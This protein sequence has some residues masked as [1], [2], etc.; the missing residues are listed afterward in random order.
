MR[1]RIFK[2]VVAVEFLNRALRPP[3]L[4]ETTLVYELGKDMPRLPGE[5][6]DHLKVVHIK[7]DEQF[8]DESEPNGVYQ[9]LL[10][11][12][13]GTDLHQSGIGIVLEHSVTEVRRVYEGVPLMDM[14]KVLDEFE[15]EYTAPEETPAAQEEEGEDDAPDAKP[16]ATQANPPGNPGQP[17][18]AV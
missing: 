14:K 11:P 13:E 15:E 12:D 16:E 17:T 1:K 9:I 10:A 7:Y 6:D 2:L 5:P 8:D 18:G 3:V 4:E